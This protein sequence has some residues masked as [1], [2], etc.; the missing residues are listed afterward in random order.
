LVRRIWAATPVAS[1]T[2]GHGAL[3]LNRTV[4]TCDV[5]KTRERG[6]KFAVTSI[7]VATHMSRHF[8][9]RLTVGH[10]AF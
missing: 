9:A 4:M 3:A 7:Q 8:V 6:L 2:P 10:D 1:K 5:P